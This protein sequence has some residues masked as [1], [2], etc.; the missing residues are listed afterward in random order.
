MLPH[1]SVCSGAQGTHFAIYS[2]TREQ[3][4]LYLLTSGCTW[5]TLIALLRAKAKTFGLSVQFEFVAI[6]FTQEMYSVSFVFLAQ[7]S[8]HIEWEV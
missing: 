6:C 2:G 8:W 1:T 5:I 4:R 7:G 3:I